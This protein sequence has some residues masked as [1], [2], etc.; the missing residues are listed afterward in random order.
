M[1]VTVGDEFTKAA[2]QDALIGLLRKTEDD[3][4]RPTAAIRLQLKHAW[5]WTDG[6]QR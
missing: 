6:Q 1:R 3:H 4:A 5:G 2:D